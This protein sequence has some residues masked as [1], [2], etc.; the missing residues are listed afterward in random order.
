MH[1]DDG[2][3]FASL[4]RDNRKLLRSINDELAGMSQ[5]PEWEQEFFKRHNLNVNGE[6]RGKAKSKG[7][8]KAKPQAKAAAAE[9]E[10]SEHEA[11]DEPQ[12][13]A[14]KQHKSSDDESHECGV[15]D[16]DD[17]AEDVH[18]EGAQRFP[19][20]KW[21]EEQH[22]HQDANVD[23]SDVDSAED[24]KKQH[25]SSDDESHEC[26]VSDSDDLAEDVHVEGA[27][28]F[29][30]RKRQEEQHNHQDAN[31]DDS[32]VDSAGDDL[33]DAEFMLGRRTASTALY[34]ERA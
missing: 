26:G 32:D 17:L 8:A 5:R 6:P 10:R 2:R 29:P 16:S 33:P 20:R 22:E 11:R 12:E 4:D 34:S 28:R 13:D 23:D 15:S 7:Q 30:K 1:G 19:K 3:I 25:K 24:A 18:V 31:V 9:A 21:Q 27:Q 14:K